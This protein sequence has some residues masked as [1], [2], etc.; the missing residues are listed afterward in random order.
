M[1]PHTDHLQDKIDAIQ[2]ADYIILGEQFVWSTTS[3]TKTDFTKDLDGLKTLLQQVD[4]IL[5]ANQ[6]KKLLVMAIEPLSNKKIGGANDHSKM[7]EDNRIWFNKEIEKI[8]ESFSN[9]NIHLMTN[10]VRSSFDRNGEVIPRI[11]KDKFDRQHFELYEKFTDLSA[12]L[13]SDL[14]MITRYFFEDFN[15]LC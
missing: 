9:S 13:R 7:V 4:A 12:G 10:T 2:S 8:F 1:L 3:Q 6:E 5:E 14:S 15:N 11:G